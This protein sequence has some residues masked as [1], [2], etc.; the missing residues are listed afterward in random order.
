MVY[1]NDNQNEKIQEYAN[2]SS[3]SVFRL[4]NGSIEAWR[5]GPRL[6]RDENRETDI[7]NTMRMPQRHLSQSACRHE[8]P[9]PCV[10]TG[11]G[12]TGAATEV[13]P[14][15]LGLDAVPDPVAD[16]IG[17]CAARD[18]PG[19][20]VAL[21]R[22]VGVATTAGLVAVDVRGVAVLVVGVDG[23]VDNAVVSVALGDTPRSRSPILGSSFICSLQY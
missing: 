2:N 4:R 5:N 20:D 1:G 21:A 22:C 18:G 11:A 15:A 6:H 10:G 3:R 17:V 7:A 9:Q 16:L 13:P 23:V 19:F 12:G 14:V 8:T